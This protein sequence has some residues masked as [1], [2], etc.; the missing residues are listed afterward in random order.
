MSGDG[1]QADLDE[2]AALA[3]RLRTLMGGLGGS[4]PASGPTWQATAAAADGVH[5]SVDAASQALGARIGETAGG[6]DG[7]AAKTAK[8]E[9]ISADMVSSIGDAVTSATNPSA[10]FAGAVS[11]TVG[12]ITGA[13]TGAVADVTGSMASAV[14][15]PLASLAGVLDFA[16]LAKVTDGGGAAGGGAAGGLGGLGGLG[17]LFMGEEMAQQPGMPELVQQPTMQEDG[18]KPETGTVI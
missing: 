17:D 14:S 13:L 7:A 2:L 3:V 8:N 1:L 12:D 18:G 16:A 15:A 4:A 11:G 5:A 10:Q 9:G 6:V